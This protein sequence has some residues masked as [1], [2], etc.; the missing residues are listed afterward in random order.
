MFTKIC[1][2]CGES[3]VTAGSQSIS[4]M[5]WI[6]SRKCEVILQKKVAGKK[7]RQAGR[8]NTSPTPHRVG[9]CSPKQPRCFTCGFPANRHYSS[10]H[11]LACA[12][13]RTF[14]QNVA[15]FRLYRHR[16]LQ[17]NTRLTFAAFFKI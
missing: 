6:L 11:R 3:Q 14:R 1:R 2:N 5:V 16:L 10:D 4:R 13:C 8:P 7:G 9:I 12:F 15:R 17:E